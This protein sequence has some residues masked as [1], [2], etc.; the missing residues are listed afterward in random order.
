M[1][2]IVK[3][4]SWWYQY[5]YPAIGI[6]WFISSLFL[7]VL[8]DYFTYPNILIENYFSPYKEY[9]K[10]Y[11]TFCQA[12]T[13]SLIFFPFYFITTMIMWKKLCRKH[14]VSFR[15]P[16]TLKYALIAS[17]FFLSTYFIMDENSCFSMFYESM[18][19]DKI[20]EW[21]V[22]LTTIFDWFGAFLFNFIMMYM[23]V[24]SVNIF[25][26]INWIRG[27]NK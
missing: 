1:A 27:E 22:I 11:S 3:N 26:I 4:H 20:Y 5:W 18:S 15:F 19:R 16:W 25:F 21:M 14:S 23:I 8:V 2:H 12:I 6:T 13:F 10:N 9:V 7:G 17:S 24:F